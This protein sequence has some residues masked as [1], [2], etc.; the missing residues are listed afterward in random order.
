MADHE[1]AADPGGHPTVSSDDEALILV[2][3]HDQE[4]GY[5]SKGQCHAAD[6]ILHRA[7][8][9]FLFDARGRLLIQKRGRDKRLWPLYWSN[10]CCSHPRRGESMTIATGRRLREELGMTA[11]LEF[12]YKFTYQAS[13][14]DAGAEHELCWVYIGLANTPVRA[15]NTEIEDWRFVSPEELD[16]LMN[17]QAQLFTPWF[18]LEWA[19]LRSE[20]QDRIDHLVTAGQRLTG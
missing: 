7:F 9:V 3:E 8:S 12:L 16:R 13:F 19:Q 5:L 14:G 18:K 10:S 6:G 2:D 20:F 4:I 15:N 17:R 11:A 1:P